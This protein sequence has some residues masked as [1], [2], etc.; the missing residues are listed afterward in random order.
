MSNEQQKKQSK[1]L[2]QNNKTKKTH[3]WKKQNQSWR[4][5]IHI[6]KT[7]IY[8]QS[9]FHNSLV[10]YHWCNLY[11]CWFVLVF[12]VL[13]VISFV[14]FCHCEF[15]RNKNKLTIART[16]KAKTLSTIFMNT[17]FQRFLSTFCEYLFSTFCF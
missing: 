8:K 6:T 17:F 13:Y 7:L 3:K 9:Q 1:H 15:Q 4:E 10:M 16:K 14:F 2:R 5:W 11:L 12:I